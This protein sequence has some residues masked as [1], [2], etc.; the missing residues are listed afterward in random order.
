M[1]IASRLLSG[2]AIGTALACSPAAPKHDAAADAQAIRDIDARW[3]EFIVAKNDSAIAAIYDS[4]AVL[5]PPNMPSMNGAGP[6]RAFWAGLWG[7]NASLTLVVDE[8]LVDGDLALDRGRYTFSVP[9]PDGSQATE[10]GKYLV[11]WRRIGGQWKAV[12]DIYNSDTPPAPPPAAA[13]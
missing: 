10:A 6:I 9:Q 11:G 4:A 1:R 3:N 7:L 13:K 2:L 8:V 12:S 5:M